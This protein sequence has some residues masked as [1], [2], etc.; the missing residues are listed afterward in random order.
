MSANLKSEKKLNNKLYQLLGIKPVDM[1][2]RPNLFQKT[3]QKGYAPM[4]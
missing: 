3:G 4:L 1:I 2:W